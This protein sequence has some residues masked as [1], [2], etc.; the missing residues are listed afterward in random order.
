MMDAVPFVL[1]FVALFRVSMEDAVQIWISWVTVARCWFPRDV[2]WN[3]LVLKPGI[4]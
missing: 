4:N 1:G 2:F 3:D